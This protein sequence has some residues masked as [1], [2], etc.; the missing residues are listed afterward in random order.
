MFCLYGCLSTMCLPSVQGNQNSLSDPLKLEWQTVVTHHMGSGNQT[1]VLWK[2]SQWS[3]LLSHLSSL[4][5]LFWNSVSYCC[6]GWIW[7]YYLFT[8]YSYCSPGWPWT[9]C[10][11]VSC[12]G[13]QSENLYTWC[14]ITRLFCLKL[15]GQVWIVVLYSFTVCNNRM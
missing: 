7:T 3:E 4:S 15:T 1:W 11:S 8:I 13:I 2:N 12:A 5:L 14:H 10:L 9:S 6:S